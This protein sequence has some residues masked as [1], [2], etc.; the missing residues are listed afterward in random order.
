MS[1]QEVSMIIGTDPASLLRL[2]LRANAW[3]SGL[4]G[5]LYL[6]AADPITEFLGL[7]MP[8]WMVRTL[9]P[10]LLVYAIWLG[11]IS[12]RSTL[13]SR[14]VWSAIVLDAT[15][16]IGSAIL[17]LG[18]FL[19]FTRSGLWAVVI[20]ADIVACFTILQMYALFRYRSAS[21]LYPRT[22]IVHQC[23]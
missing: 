6:L 2:S 10:G 3:F 11:L 4:S 18:E 17:L 16:V 23:H 9:G 15:W 7:N 19:P 5:L 22:T 13:D 20:V 1:F 12:R 8:P 14:E 21:A